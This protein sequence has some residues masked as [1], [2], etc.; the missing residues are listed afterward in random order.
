MKKYILILPVLMLFFLMACDDDTTCVYE[1]PDNKAVLMEQA[2]EIFEAIARNPETYDRQVE[3]T[4]GLYSNIS[5]LLPISDKAI[6]QRGEAR[7]KAFGSLI[8]AVARNPYA[9]EK[10]DSA[11]I[12]FFGAYNEEI[13]SKEMEDITVAYAIPDLNT[14]IAR[15]PGVD[16]LLNVVCKKYLNFEFITNK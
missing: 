10:L 15:N 1:E 2:G 3:I 4:S 5:E 11:A 12:I 7:G 9:Y 8:Y 14:A 6:Q 13:I 16:S